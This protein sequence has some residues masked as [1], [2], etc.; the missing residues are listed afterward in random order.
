MLR[1]TGAAALI[2]VDRPADGA[3]WWPGRRDR[4]FGQ[5]RVSRSDPQARLLSRPD[6]GHNVLRD[7]VR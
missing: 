1:R 7:E 4:L 3:Q 6:E 5:R 2:A